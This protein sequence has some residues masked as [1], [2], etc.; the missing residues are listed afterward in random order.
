MQNFDKRLL[1][2]SCPS[3]SLPLCPSVCPH[4]TTRL[5][6]HGFRWNFILE[7]ISKTCRKNSNF[8]KIRQKRVFYVKAFS[9]LC[10]YFA[11]FFLEK[12]CFRQTSYTKSKHTHFIFSNFFRKSLRVWD[13]FEK[14]CGNEGPKNEVTIWRIQLVCWISKAICMHVYAHTYAPGH[15]HARARTHAHTHRHT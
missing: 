5:P 15:R 4:G 10:Q 7:L 1:A 14:F 8:L 9:H 13:N 12:K 3:V 2:S 6:L 11:E